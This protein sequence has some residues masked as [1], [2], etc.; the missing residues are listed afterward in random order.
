MRTIATYALRVLAPEDAPAEEGSAFAM[1]QQERRVVANLPAMLEAAQENLQ[2][3]LPVDWT[4][5]VER[6]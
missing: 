5:E 3:L 2:D 6:Q 1:Q 4:V